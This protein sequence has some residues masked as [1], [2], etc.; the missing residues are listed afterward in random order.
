MAGLPN[1]VDV[2]GSGASLPHLTGAG[3]GDLRG[4]PPGALDPTGR[5]ASG[6]TLVEL[7]VVIAIIGI[8]IGLLLPAVQAARE[9][10]RRTQC[11]NNLKQLGLALQNYHSSYACLPAGTIIE[12]TD[13]SECN[14]DCRGTSFYVSILDYFEEAAVEEYYDYEQWNR[15]LHQPPE[16]RAVLNSTRIPMYVCPS[17]TKWDDHTPRRDYFG[18]MG[19]KTA[20]AHGWRGDVFEDGLMFLNSFIKIEHIDDGSA[21]TIAVGESVHPSRWGAGP[22]YGDGCVGGPATWWFGGATRINDPNSLSVGRVLRS[23]K[24]PINADVLCIKPHDDNDVP[25]G[26]MH[27]RGANFAYADGHVEFIDEAIDWETYQALSTRKGGETIE[28]EG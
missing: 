10:A 20:R 17:N 15:W 14:V 28:D 21:H 4:R 18:C 12:Y 19:G 25:F 11:V 8:L 1:H 22:G 13:S 3:R 7:L 6:F 2:V 5:T 16:K 9:A 26:S 24:H 23:T 27:P